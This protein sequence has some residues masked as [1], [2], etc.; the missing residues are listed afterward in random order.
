MT[1]LDP[2]QLRVP[3]GIAVLDPNALE[4][5]ET[6]VVEAERRQAEEIADAAGT[7]LDQLP[8]VLRSL[9]LRILGV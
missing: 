4:R 3:P 6:L 9:T 1:E 2:G 8:A 5:I 7:A